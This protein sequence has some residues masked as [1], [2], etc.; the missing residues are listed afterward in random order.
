LRIV[1]TCFLTLLVL[2]QPVAQ[3]HEAGQETDGALGLKTFSDPASRWGS[4]VEA[5][6]EEAYRAC[7]RTYIID[8]KVMTLRLPFAQND[9]RAELTESVLKVE[10]GGKADPERLWDD[11]ER[12]I[13]TPDFKAYLSVLSDGN[14]AVIIFDITFRS[15]SISR[16]IFDIA[17]M[18]AGAYRGLPH[19]PYVL[20][21]GKGLRQSDIYN[22][23]YCIGRVGIDC[24]GFVWHILSTTAMAGGFD[25]GATL[26]QALKVPRGANPSLYAGTSFFD[27]RSSE[28]IQVQDRVGDLLP[29]DILLFRGD[30]G[31][32]VHSAIIQ[33]V[34]L[35][36]GLIRYL[37]STDEAPPEERGVH[38]SFI[39][40]D[41]AK[42]ELSLKDASIHWSQRRFPPFAGEKASAFSNDGERYR[43]FPEFGGGKA[44]R[45]KAMLAPLQ[46]LAAP[47]LP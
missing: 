24:S 6:I 38:E 5:V 4:G 22:Y 21:Q 43:A 15:W 17:R 44:V 3:S 16:D 9:E 18:K 47:A 41:P 29:G 37:Q 31:E 20:T 39:R 28:L 13:Q 34:D 26:R 1:V 12:I 32:A 19:K 10:G 35:A 46:R 2:L 45:L 40:F 14:D 25:L 36:S 23:L 33:S 11:I 42:P 8:G 7:F 30:R 27:S